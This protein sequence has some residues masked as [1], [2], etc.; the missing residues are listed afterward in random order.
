MFGISLGNG[1]SLLSVSLTI[2]LSLSVSLKALIKSKDSKE[3]AGSVE[4]ANEEKSI[5]KETVCWELS[6]VT[7]VLANRLLKLTF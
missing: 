1:W 4:T 7:S 5:Q 2:S 3:G 6:L